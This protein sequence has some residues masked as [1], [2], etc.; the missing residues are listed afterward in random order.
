[1]RC[2]AYGRSASPRTWNT[3]GEHG[4]LPKLPHT[5]AA[6]TRSLRRRREAA[7][8]SGPICA[9][10]TTAGCVWSRFRAP[11][12]AEVSPGSAYEQSMY[13]GCSASSSASSGSPSGTRRTT[14]G[15][16]CTSTA[17]HTTRCPHASS[18][19]GSDA[20]WARV[21]RAGPV[22]NTSNV[23]E[24]AAAGAGTPSQIV[25][26]DACTAQWV[27][28][29]SATSCGSSW[30][31]P[32][33][34]RDHSMANSVVATNV[35]ATCAVPASEPSSRS[36]GGSDARSRSPSKP[37]RR[38]EIRFLGHHTTGSCTA[39]GASAR[40]AQSAV[41]RCSVTHILRFPSLVDMRVG[42]TYR[43]A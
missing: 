8:R 30:A 36:S 20:S 17:C 25:V 5:A 10:C 7:A 39:N 43:N 41:V 6:L 37:Y 11:S 21:L 14:D 32:A 16:P 9:G 35:P 12:P 3:S 33:K 15:S 19:M 31:W 40:R 34:A 42:G 38:Q 27:S 28:A 22:T 1:M 4:A 26:G 13:V 2:R 23:N 18:A 29:E 24:R